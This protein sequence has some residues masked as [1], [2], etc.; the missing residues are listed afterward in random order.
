M[1]D[2]QLYL[3]IYVLGL[4]FVFYYNIATGVFS[5]LGRFQD[6][7]LFLA[8]SSTA[9]V[10]MDVSLR[11]HLRMGVAGVAWATFLCQGLPVHWPWW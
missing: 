4:P 5:A 11:H 3:D 7:F 2:S 9:N 8:V 1:A 10:A 6:P